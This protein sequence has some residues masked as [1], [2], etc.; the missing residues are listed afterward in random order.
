MIRGATTPMGDPVAKQR[1]RQAVGKGMRTDPL[2]RM[3]SQLTEAWIHPALGADVE[4]VVGPPGDVG[5][6]APGAQIDLTLLDLVPVTPARASHRPTPLLLQARCLVTASGADADQ[7]IVALAFHAL[8]AGQPELERDG[9]APALWAALG[10]KARPAL[11]ARALLE[12]SREVPPVPLVR[13]VVTEWS[14]RRQLD[15]RIVGPGDVPIAGA[16][17]EVERLG[18]TTVSD[19]RGEFHLTVPAG[20]SAPTVSVT[21]KGARLAVRADPPPGEPLVIHVPLPEL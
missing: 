14:R 18:L 9:L 2:S 13:Q 20:S 4:V 6:P 11:V 3:W 1:V 15:G 10:A 5:A 17:V 19:H 12:Q 8:E 21:A 16:R 7:W